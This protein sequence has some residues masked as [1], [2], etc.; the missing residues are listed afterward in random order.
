MSIAVVV[1]NKDV[2]LLKRRCNGRQIHHNK[3][4][5]TKYY[6]GSLQYVLASAR[7]LCNFSS[8]R[9][10]ENMS[11]AGTSFDSS[12]ERGCGQLGEYINGFF[13]SVRKVHLRVSSSHLIVEVGEFTVS[14]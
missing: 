12:N 13:M 6:Y 2:W 3:G 5:Y 1:F 11:L 8:L 10:Q 4:I 14:V 7:S 9:L